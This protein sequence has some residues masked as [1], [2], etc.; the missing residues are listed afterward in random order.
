M[1]LFIIVFEVALVTVLNY[2]TIDTHVSLDVLYCLPIIQAAQMPM[3]QSNRQSELL[4][5]L[6]IGFL[7][8]AIWSLS[9]ALLTPSDFPLGA[10]ALNVFSRGVTFTLLG[11]V[12][13]R[14][15]KEREQ[16]HQDR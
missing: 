6:L 10:L 8:G 13:A 9:E 5:P 16:D 2:A 11:K 4:I 7:V 1:S 15:W 12:V 3:L 14:L